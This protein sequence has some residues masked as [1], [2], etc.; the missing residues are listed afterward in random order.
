MSAMVRMPRGH[1]GSD[2]HWY[3]K[4]ALGLLCRHACWGGCEVRVRN[5]LSIGPKQA[6]GSI[7]KGIGVRFFLIISP[8]TA[9]P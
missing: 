9:L 3:I 2:V 8:M 4:V 7:T 1:I 6:H 5:E